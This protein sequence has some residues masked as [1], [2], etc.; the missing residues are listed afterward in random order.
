MLF[1]PKKYSISN[2]IT[3][4]L[5]FVMSLSWIYENAH[6]YHF[7][8][9]APGWKCGTG[10]PTNDQL[11]IQMFLGLAGVVTSIFIIENKLRPFIGGAFQFLLVGM[12]IYVISLA[13]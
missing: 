11:W 12:G 8:N 5:V 13:W 4:A 3:G 2:L 1:K 7:W 10:A 6:E 9:F